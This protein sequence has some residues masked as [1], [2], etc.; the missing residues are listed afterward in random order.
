MQSI[1]RATTIITSL[2]KKFDED[3]AKGHTTLTLGTPGDVGTKA[4]D[5]TSIVPLSNKDKYKSG[6]GTLLYLT[7][8][9]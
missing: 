2:E 3:V 4:V 6:V 7:K 5:E 8:H 9:L 1:V